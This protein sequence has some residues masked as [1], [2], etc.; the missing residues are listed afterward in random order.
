MEL[1]GV[2]DGDPALHRAAACAIPA[3]LLPKVMADFTVWMPRREG[4]EWETPVSGVRGPAY[5]QPPVVISGSVLCWFPAMPVPSRRMERIAVI[6]CSGSGKTVLARGLA[7]CLGLP[8]VH[9]DALYYDSD[10]N[11]TAMDRFAG[12]QGE[13]VAGDRWIIEGNYASTLPIRLERAD[14]VVF[15]DLPARTCL[16]GIVRRH[17][18]YHGGQH[19]DGVYDRI[20]GAVITYV[21]GYRRAMRPR[22]DALIGERGSHLRRVTL[23]SRRQVRRFLEGLR[24]PT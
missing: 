6:G 19:A 9:L 24:R 13:L 2:E 8:V 7:D 4:Q 15:L 16:W 20:N 14:T 5:F 21:L 12:L 10:W 3:D 18:K 22:I 11:P 17:W 23:T 1:G